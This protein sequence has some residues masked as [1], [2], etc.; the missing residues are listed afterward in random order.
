MEDCPCRDLHYKN[1]ILLP[2]TKFLML[3]WASYKQEQLFLK[4][5]SPNLEYL[6]TPTYRFRL[7]KIFIKEKILQKVGKTF[8]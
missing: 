2:I 6:S 7:T 8:K 4:Q 3:G 1:L 5:L